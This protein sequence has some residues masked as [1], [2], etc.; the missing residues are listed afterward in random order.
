MFLIPSCLANN[1]FKPAL[2]QWNRDIGP[3][4]NNMRLVLK[5]G[6][7]AAGHGKN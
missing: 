5:G 3:K 7:Q 2:P 6:L 1:Q 4:A